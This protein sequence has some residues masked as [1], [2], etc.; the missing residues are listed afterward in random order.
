[1]TDYELNILKRIQDRDI[2]IN[3][4]ASFFSNMYKALILDL[5]Q[6][7]KLRGKQIP[8]IVINTGDDTMY[9]EVKGQDQRLAPLEQTNENYVYN[10]IP[11]CTLTFSGINILP[12]Q[13]TSPYADGQFQLNVDDNL[14]TMV[15]EFRRMPI[16]TTVQLKYA[17]D[18]FTD[19]LDTAQSIISNCAF[20][21]NFYFDYMGQTINATYKIPDSV[22]GEL[23]VEFDGITTDSKLKTIDLD[24]EIETNLP[25][26]MERTVRFA[27]A[28]IATMQSNVYETKFKQA[29][30]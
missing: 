2:D 15:G 21:R 26:W 23:Q 17:L 22:D 16:Q 4:Q 20:I 30:V 9:L 14:Y 7:V 18:T 25:V 3:A 24:V 8:H 28:R 6:Y 27:D 19:L 10:N 1:M 11:R 5:N 13:L 29:E 12:D